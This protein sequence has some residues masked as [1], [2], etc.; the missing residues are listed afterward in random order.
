M[1]SVGTI[2]G[3]AFRL[4]SERPAAVLAW[5]AIYF[6]GTVAMALAMRPFARAQAMMMNGGDPQ[7]ALAGL[8]AMFGGAMLLQL[9]FFLI[10][11]ILFAAALRAVLRPQEGG[12]AFIRLGGDELRLI[13]LTIFMVFCFYFGFV[14]V[15]IVLTLVV[16]VFAAAGGPGAAMIAGLLEMFVLLGLFVWLWVRLSLALPLTF[17]RQTFVLA[18]SWRLTRGRFWTLFGGY[19]IV[20]VV[21]AVLGTAAAAVT[22]GPYLQEIA[23]GGFRLQAL[24][25]AAQAQLARQMAGIDAMMVAGWVLSALVGGLSLALYGGATATAARRLAGDADGMAGTF[26]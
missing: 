13:G 15:A 3:G 2:V 4:V 18:E 9:A 14:V 17:L 22:A 8:Q 19:F 23:R 21:V 25:A 12:F 1:L 10:Y 5:T 20:F 11:M 16:V 26:A 24:Q 7:A 6:L